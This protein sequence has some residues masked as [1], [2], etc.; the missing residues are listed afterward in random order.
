M[1]PLKLEMTAFGTYAEKTVIDFTKLDNGVYLITGDTGAG[2][3]TIFDA[4]IFALYGNA[5]G[6]YR[7]PEMLHSDYVDKSVPT[8]VRLEFEV[9]GNVH[10]IER[11]LRYAKERSTGQYKD[12]PDMSVCFHEYGKTAVELKTTVEAR[13]K[14][15]LGLDE[16]QFKKIIMLAQGE[17][18]RFLHADSGERG[19]ILGKLFDTKEY[20]VFQNSLKAAL[21]KM[22]KERTEKGALIDMKLS[23]FIRPDDLSPEESALLNKDNPLFMETLERLSRDDNELLNKIRS[24]SKALSAKKDEMIKRR[25]AAK[26]ANERLMEKED[27]QRRYNILL[28]EIPKI[29]AAEREKVLFEKALHVVYHE[30]K[31]LDDIS[32]EIEM[33]EKSVSELNSNGKRLG[34]RRIELQKAAESTAAMDN[35]LKNVLIPGISEIDRSLDQYAEVDILRAKITANASAASKLQWDKALAESRLKKLAEDKKSITERIRDTGNV[36]ERTEKL[37]AQ[38]N[39]AV[40]RHTMLDDLRSG[41]LR[42]NALS[43]E[44]GE[45]VYNLALQHE[46]C[47]WA[48]NE[49]NRLYRRFIN[50]QASCLAAELRAEIMRTGRGI[51]PVCRTEFCGGE[52]KF[53]DVSAETPDRNAVD[54]AD[55]KRKAAERKK[56][57]AEKALDN[58]RA[59][60]SAAKENLLKNAAP[61]FGSSIAWEQLASGEMIGNAIAESENTLM[62]LENELE[63][64]R[65]DGELLD[66]LTAMHENTEKQL[67]AEQERYDTAAVKLADTMNIAAALNAQLEEKKRGL[68]F[69]SKAEAEKEKQLLEKEFQHITDAIK[70][71]ED[72]LK[73]VSEAIAANDGMLSTK[74]AQL[75]DAQSRYVQQQERYL[76]VMTHSGFNDEGEYLAALSLSGNTD[77]ESWLRA[78]NEM[79][80][81]YNSA[82][83]SA[84]EVMV[85]CTEAADGIEYADLTEIDKELIAVNEVIEAASRQLMAQSE[86]CS[87]NNSIISDIKA[88][89]AEMDSERKAY[90][91]IRRLSDTAQPT[92]GIKVT[93]ER[94]VI[95][96]TFRE[97][98]HYA[99]LRLIEVSGGRFEFVHSIKAQHGGSTAG[100]ELKLLDN[101]TGI[102][103]P[104]QSVSGGEGFLAS[105]SLALGLSDV[106]Q[107][108]SGGVKIDSMFIDEGFGSLDGGHLDNAINILMSLAGDS[109]QIGIISHVDKLEEAIH[110]K[111]AVK[112]SS[113]GSTVTII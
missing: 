62:Q 33:T 13:V 100:L 92:S 52:H 55:E 14:E 80:N 110:R 47:E 97:I 1:R 111:L 26:T 90:E 87:L 101:R 36:G 51:C 83:C 27:A 40:D 60:I 108:H 95:G 73:N 65:A 112:G 56:Q 21:T 32:R 38:Y 93:F 63:K 19:V 75:A 45:K 71:A 18:S 39:T 94:F 9:G 85:R 34:F 68:K 88:V 50:G 22:E 77:G 96:R 7:S 79:I 46:K 12:K 3:T 37:S 106:V 72:D 104:V 20:E 24:D 8:V 11:K 25:E 44:E 102:I 81:S 78:R 15:L 31:L 105:L 10:T 113:T 49:Y 99:N 6:E 70:K 84:K 30:K 91:R 43:D 29:E 66:K 4:I 82:L 59:Q 23:G 89:R 53:A 42:V 16:K 5:S 54:A 67:Q 2:K 58:V 103:R 57:S 98:L 41:I 64:C 69:G 48:D 17:F 74:S 35:K 28:G 61:V 109:R 86:K 76:T 107:N